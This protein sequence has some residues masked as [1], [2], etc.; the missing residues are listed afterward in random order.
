MSETE[1]SHIVDDRKLNWDPVVQN[2]SNDVIRNTRTFSETIL[3][4]NKLK[5]TFEPKNHIWHYSQKLQRKNNFFK[6][7]KIIEGIQFPFRL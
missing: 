2:V 4:K 5:E 6:K 7:D 1:S 3:I